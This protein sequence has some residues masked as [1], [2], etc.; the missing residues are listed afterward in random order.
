MALCYIPAEDTRSIEANTIIDYDRCLA[1]AFG[2]FNHSSHGFGRSLLSY[3]DLNERHLMN[4]REEV[5][6]EEA[7]RPLGY[8]RKISDRDHGSVGSEYSS[9]RHHGFRLFDHLMLY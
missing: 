5:H 6:A 8:L 7:I 1:V 4:R 3:D 9:L 2:H